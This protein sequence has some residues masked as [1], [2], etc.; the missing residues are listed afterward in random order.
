MKFSWV[1][2]KSRKDKEKELGSSKENDGYEGLGKHPKERIWKNET[3]KYF[4]MI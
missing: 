2:E 4:V 3:G 1:Y